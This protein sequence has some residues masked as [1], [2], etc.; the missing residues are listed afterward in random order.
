[1]G[2]V[3]V[4]YRGSEEDILTI[5]SY[6]L[7]LLV[8]CGVPGLL[9]F[10]GFVMI[11]IVLGIHQY[12]GNSDARAAAVLPFVASLTAF[13]VYRLALAQN[14]NHIFLFILLGLWARFTLFWFRIRKRKYDRQARRPC[15]RRGFPVRALFRNNAPHDTCF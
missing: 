5:D 7:R 12:L 15:G 14:E 3:V 1:M 10:F 2:A 11:A 9:S 13:L 4:G 8:E 6:V